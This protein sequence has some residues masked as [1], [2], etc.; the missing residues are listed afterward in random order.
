MDTEASAPSPE[1][2]MRDLADAM[3][4]EYDADI[5][6][7]NGDIDYAAYFLLAE[8]VDKIEQRHKNVALILVTGGGDP[9]A[10]YRIARHLR[11]RYSHVRVL[12]PGF[13][14]SSGTLIAL[15]AD[16][17]TMGD[18]GELGPLD[19]QIP[20]HDDVGV[21]DSGLTATTALDVLRN[22]SYSTF[23][24]VFQEIKKRSRGQIS[25][26]TATEIAASL[27]I[28]LYTPISAQI[29]A[30]HLGEIERASRITEY[31]GRRLASENVREDAIETLA[32]GFPSHSF[33]IDRGEARVFFR[34]VQE[35]SATERKL[36][37]ELGQ[38]ALHCLHDASGDHM[39]YVDCL[40]THTEKDNE[41]QDSLRG[42][43]RNGSAPPST[44]G[45][46]RPEIRDSSQSDGINPEEAKPIDGDGIARAR[47]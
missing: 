44:N 3:A 19:I 1:R 7:F 34:T 27:T 15:A 28:G 21:L 24:K 37:E 47:S 45:G 32:N 10:A 11:L 8:E 35:P 42:E 20:K 2:R 22:E 17:I 29:Q 13:C 9:D 18:Y 5:L 16:A 30:M 4:Q 31:Y 23:D 39:T 6:V 40:S 43:Q 25:F 38:A 26:K 14:K 36:F 12:V 41:A 46:E 33:V